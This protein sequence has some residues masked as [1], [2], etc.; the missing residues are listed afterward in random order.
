MWQPTQNLKY[1]SNKNE[2]Q[3]SQMCILG[4]LQVIIVPNQLTLTFFYFIRGLTQCYK[5][6]RL[7]I[8]NLEF[9]QQIYIQ[10]IQQSCGGIRNMRANQLVLS[11]IQSYFPGFIRV[12]LSYISP[13]FGNQTALCALIS[14]GQ[15]RARCVS[16]CF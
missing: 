11:G 9:V 7:L 8:I 4:Q 12:S 15:S 13:Y 1:L 5:I 16:P 10:Q 14:F 6:E 2:T 3:I